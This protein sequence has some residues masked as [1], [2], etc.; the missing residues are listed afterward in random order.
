MSPAATDQH[1]PRSASHHR[2]ADLVWHITG[3]S[4]RAAAAAI[5]ADPRSAQPQSFDEAIDVVAAALV[6]VRVRVPVSA[7]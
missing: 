4:P 6:R 2:L 7:A 5:E 3:C 1:R